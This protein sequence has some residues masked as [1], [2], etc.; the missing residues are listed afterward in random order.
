MN[1]SSA[2]H[3]TELI[4]EAL[5]ADTDFR[6]AVI[7]DLAEEFALRVRWDGPVAARRW[8][9]RESIRVAPYLL[10]DWWRSLRWTNVAYFANVLLWSSM[11]VMALESL[12]QRSVRGLVLLIHGTPLDALPVSAGVASLMLCWTLI[13]GA[14]AGYVA[15]RIGRRAPLPSALLLGGTLTGV[16]IWS[17]LNVAPPWFLAA[18]VTTLIAGTIAGGLFRACTPGALP[19]RSSAN[20]LQRTARP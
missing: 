3:R 10:R 14:F 6:E 7:G 16:M 15:A 13:D 4:L 8:Y 18:N 17:G 2:P 9:H 12:L 20:Q 11:S 1:D 19:V 5:G